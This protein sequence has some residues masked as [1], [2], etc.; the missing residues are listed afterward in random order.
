MGLTAGCAVCHDH[1]F[2]PISQKEFYSL[3]AF[4]H[5]AADPAMDGN[6][7]RTPPVAPVKSEK[8]IW[9][10]TE[11]DSRILE[12]EKGV[13]TRVQSLSYTD[14]ATLNP[15]PSA[16][17]VETV[18]LEDGT[19]TGARLQGSPSWVKSSDGPVKFGQ[20]SLQQRSD[21]MIQSVYEGLSFAVPASAKVFAWVRLDPA[22]L[23]KMVMLQFFQ[24]DWEHRVVWGDAGAT[25]WG[26]QGKPSRMHAGPL[27][28]AGEWVRLE[29]DADAVGL[30]S[31]Q[32]VS[33]I[34]YTQHGGLVHWD[35]AGI[36]GRVDPARD[37]LT[38]LSVWIAQ[39]QGKEPKE[40]PEN[41]R[42][43]FKDV[44]ADKRTPEQT[45]M[46]REYYLNKVCTETRATMDP[47]NTAV[48]DLRQQ[49]D[50]FQDQI[51]QT[52]IW[53]DMDKPRDSFVMVRGQY[54]APGEK[55]SRAV[56]AVFPVMKQAGQVP[57]RLDL[58]RWLVS[59]EHPLTARVTVNRLWQQF[60]GVGL[61][62]TADD[63]G[64]QGEPPSHPELLDWLAV[65]FQESGW[66]VKALV[67]TLVT[68]AAYRQSAAVP[69]A[70]LQRDPENRWLARG[71][72]FRLDAEQLRDNALFVSGLLDGT[73][74]GKGVRPYQ[75]PNIWEPVAYSGSNT[76]NY[77]QDAGS[78]LYRRSLYVFFK[79]TAP[80]PFMATFDAP[81]REQFCSRRERSNT[82]LQALQLLN[83]VQHF[84]AARGLASRMMTEGGA[85]PEDRI[86]F[87]FK[88]VLSRPP[89][90]T[91]LEVVRSTFGRFLERYQA[92]PESA[93]K[94]IHVGE[95][96]PR[97]G[98]PETEL[99]AYTLTANLLLNLDETVT[100]N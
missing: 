23:P 63:F 45:R 52:F 32:P 19:P 42:K 64:S 71:P 17:D 61:V 26:T 97:S 68:S 86:R 87:A 34:A 79:R 89:S 75:P 84:E 60:F 58:A 74:G 96:A 51:P 12:A 38:S 6:A 21:G 80:P 67:R 40:L 13:A 90:A 35:H 91:E 70:L 83:D 57:N 56:P 88:T 27:P 14:P 82:P 39:N 22:S 78:A 59:S 18:W 69:P 2:D 3:Y 28:K 5:S 36:M 16:R 99:A 50:K 72:R 30:K 20:S 11:F 95:S 37:P 46:L 29:F 24:G 41:L 98:L 81:N 7:L 94:A 100:R 85:R 65:S 54:D 8:D 10:L 25:D 62:K 4:F 47:L 93:R 53:R 33:G 1:K 92:D 15:P 44:P 49:R 76:R 77:R 43:I 66:D 55:V 31:G 9:K 48:I 73:L